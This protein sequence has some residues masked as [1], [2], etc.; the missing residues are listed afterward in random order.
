EVVM[1]ADRRLA[2]ELIKR[3]DEPKQLRP[4]LVRHD[5]ETD[6]RHAYF[7]LRVNYG[8]PHPMAPPIG[9]AALCWGVGNGDELPISG[10]TTSG[11][12]KD[13]PTRREGDRQ[14][15]L[16]PR[17]ERSATGC[18]GPRGSRRGCLSRSNRNGAHA[19]DERPRHRPRRRQPLRR[20]FARRLDPCRR[21]RA[22]AD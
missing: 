18:R 4:A 6:R 13:V 9:R 3:L 8:R 20:Q 14:Y 1:T 16:W 19:I 21:A 5:D 11:Y 2:V 10:W 7:H 15:R 12:H 17:C 22:P